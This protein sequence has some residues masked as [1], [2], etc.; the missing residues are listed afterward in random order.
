LV[1]GTEVAVA[2]PDGHRAA[3]RTICST[4][5]FS[6]MNQYL[7]YGRA[8]NIELKKCCLAGGI[9]VMSLLGACVSAPDVSGDSSGQRVDL[10][11]ADDWTSM[12]GMTPHTFDHAFATTPVPGQPAQ[13]HRRLGRSG[14]APGVEGDTDPNCRVCHLDW[15]D[16]A[17]RQPASPR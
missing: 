4:P 5:N 12:D 8:M 11:I 16:E 7:L 9:L 10:P 15:A 2:Q 13:A 14:F 1:L 17:V 6:H 3:A